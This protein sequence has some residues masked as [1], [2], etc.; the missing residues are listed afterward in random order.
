M[1]ST[2]TPSLISAVP[3]LEGFLS[4]FP[5]SGTLYLD[6]E[7][8]SLSRYGT[9]SLITILIHPQ[10]VVRIIDILALG[11]LAFTTV[12]NNGNTLKSIFEDPDVPKCA[13]DIRNDA[14]ALWAL[15]QVSLVGVTDIQL[16]AMATEVMCA[17]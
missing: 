3:E 16:L 12:S 15:Y 14:D 9:I 1:T 6:L 7:G 13:W 8:N 4:S 17:G 11:K 5:P 2:S 10:K